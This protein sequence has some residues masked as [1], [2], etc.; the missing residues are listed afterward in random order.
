MAETI[1]LFLPQGEPRGVR[2][3]DITTRIVQAML[4]PRTKLQKVFKTSG[5][6]FVPDP[7]EGRPRLAKSAHKKSR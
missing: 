6:V 1:Q 3:A 7:Y 5:T 2:I 4:V